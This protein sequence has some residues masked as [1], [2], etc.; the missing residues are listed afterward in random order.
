MLNNNKR[1]NGDTN[2]GTKTTDQVAAIPICVV[3]TAD[4]LGEAEG[5]GHSVGWP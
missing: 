1:L 4:A 5:G 2:R 3:A